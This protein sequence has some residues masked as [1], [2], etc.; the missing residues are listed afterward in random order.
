[1]TLSRLLPLTLVLATLSV[2]ALASVLV[3]LSGLGGRYTLHPDDAS[4]SP[5]LG[6]ASQAPD[7]TP[8][9]ATLFSE[10]SERPL[11][12]ADRRPEEVR[13]DV[14]EEVETVALLVTSIVL[15][16]QL[17]AALVRR[18]GSDRSER[19]RVG[20]EVPGSPGWRLL[21]LQPRMAVFDGP[22][23]EVDLALRVFDGEGGEPPTQVVPVEQ[24]APAQ[25]RRAAA[26]ERARRELAAREQQA[27]PAAADGAGEASEVVG[28]PTGEAEPPADVPRRGR[29]REAEPTADPPTPEEQ[30][31][32]IRR[33]IEE[34]REQLRQRAQQRTDELQ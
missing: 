9:D 3:A 19:V 2:W 29:G 31:Q 7:V 32:A 26:E 5:P 28:G 13:L 14:E 17:Q 4:L 22:D 21:S 10:A 24:R 25:A 16:P 27:E 6:D 18:E 8:F 20:E 1:M 30:A 34:R 15:T 12:S 11:F 23:G 33:R